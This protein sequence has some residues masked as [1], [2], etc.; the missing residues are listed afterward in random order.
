[1]NI[2]EKCTVSKA[3]P[4]AFPHVKNISL[5]GKSDIKLR[6]G[7]KENSVL[8]LRTQNKRHGEGADTE[9]IWQISGTMIF[10]KD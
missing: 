1:M 3:I 5:F 10:W 4:M 6:L 2:L 8:I 9:Q 7:Q